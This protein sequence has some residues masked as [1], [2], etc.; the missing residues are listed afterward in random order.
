MTSR[1]VPSGCDPLDTYCVQLEPGDSNLMRYYAKNASIPGAIWNAPAGR[2][3]GDPMEDARARGTRVLQRQFEAEKNHYLP[4]AFPELRAQRGAAPFV[5][6]EIEQWNVF[7]MP[8][9]FFEAPVAL[10][11]PAPM[12]AGMYGAGRRERCGCS[13]SREK[14]R[15][16]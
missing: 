15:V 12:G 2:S 9:E 13:S 4:Y 7:L 16:V 1:S 8:S 14:K 3:G 11:E 6:P 5:G 10:T